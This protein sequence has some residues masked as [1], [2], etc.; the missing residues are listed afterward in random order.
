MWATGLFGCLQGPDVGFNCC[1]QTCCCGPCVWAEA[2][3]R[4]G[5]QEAT[6]YALL[7]ACGGNSLADEV[8]GYGARRALMR[9]YDIPAESTL[10][11]CT[12]TCCCAP[13][14]RLQEINTVL[15]RENL[16][17]GCA[18]LRPKAPQRISRF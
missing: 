16:T 8:A 13:C 10:E 14:A 12:I 18:T 3:R 9:K 1:V 6:L 5:V 2:L 11:T 17:W 7:C 15:A 4:A